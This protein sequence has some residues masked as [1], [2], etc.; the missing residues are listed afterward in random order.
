M[1]HA[2]ELAD[3]AMLKHD[4]TRLCQ[5][6]EACFYEEFNT[7]LIGGA[8]EPLY[9]PSGKAYAHHTV[10]YRHD[11]F[12]SALHE[13]AHWC[14]AG[15]ARRQELDFGYWY[16]GDDRSAAQQRAFESVEYKPQALEWIFSIACHWRFRVSLDNLTLS[17]EGLL[18]SGEFEAAIVEQARAW[19]DGGLPERADRFYTALCAEFDNCLPLHKLQLDFSDFDYATNEVM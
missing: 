8:N 7:L 14:L 16:S 15:E 10:Y 18:D 11:Y 17:R 9:Q 1:A 2:T 19:R 6:F 4:A 5:V 3:R 13:A 12:A